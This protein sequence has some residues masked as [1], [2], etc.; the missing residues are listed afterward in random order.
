MICRH[1][2]AL[3]P[4]IMQPTCPHK[5]SVQLPSRII[6]SAIFSRGIAAVQSVT[7][8]TKGYTA[9]L[10]RYQNHLF[11]RGLDVQTVIT[12]DTEGA[13]RNWRCR[14]SFDRSA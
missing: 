10:M 6:L 1:F 12:D 8:C 13:E 14:L 5:A 9:R 7:Q 3:T 4:T 2:D 11:A